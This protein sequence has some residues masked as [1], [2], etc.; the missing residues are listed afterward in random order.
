MSKGSMMCTNT[1]H[2]GKTK[3][4]NLRLKFIDIKSKNKYINAQFA[5][6]VLVVGNV[7]DAFQFS[8]MECVV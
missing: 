6:Q 2:K 7:G 8:Q 5:L 1:K 3:K 4:E